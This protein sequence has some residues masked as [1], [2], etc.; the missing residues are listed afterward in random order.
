MHGTQSGHPV[1][2]LQTSLIRAAITL[3]VIACGLSLR[4]YGFPLGLPPFIVKYG[5]SLLWA[6]MVFLLVGFLL[7]RLA[8]T[9]IAGIA[10]GIAIVVEL[11]RL[12]HAP[13]LDAFRLTTRRR[14]AAGADLLAVECRGLLRR[15]CHR[16]VPGPPP[17]DEKGGLA[18]HPAKRT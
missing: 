15:H 7:P 12:V 13:W 11:S 18:A 8:R 3:V 1:A 16:R 17:R 14:A 10:V 4:R 2:P 9:Q 5:G 6:T